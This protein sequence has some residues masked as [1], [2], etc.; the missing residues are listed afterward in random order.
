ML[1]DDLCSVSKS[2]RANRYDADC[3]YQNK[4]R[5]QNLRVRLSARQGAEAVNDMYEANDSRCELESAEECSKFYQPN[6]AK[7]KKT[8]ECEDEL[9]APDVF[10]AIGRRR[11]MRRPS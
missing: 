7:P 6:R 2:S 9:R 5:F 10:E 3:H 11:E 4:T 1:A 8:P